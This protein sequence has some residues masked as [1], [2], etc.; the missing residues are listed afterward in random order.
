MEIL[1]DF[2]LRRCIHHVHFEGLDGT[3]PVTS[4]KDALSRMKIRNIG[5][6]FAENVQASKY[7][8]LSDEEY[9]RMLEH[10]KFLSTL[11]RYPDAP[12][13]APQEY[14]MNAL[15]L[16]ANALELLCK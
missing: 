16:L 13:G 6:T 5:T 3:E 9:G 8:D 10:V 2:D 15:M 7:D 14:E 11:W 12:K 4:V 1:F